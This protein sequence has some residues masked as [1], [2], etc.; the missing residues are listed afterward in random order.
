MHNL[1]LFD[2]G[3]VFAW[4][5]N[6]GGQTT[7]PAGLSGVVAIAA[8]YGH[9]LALKSDGKVVAWGSNASGQ[10]NVPAGLSGVIA[11]AGGL[12]HSLALKSDGTVVA[13]GGIGFGALGITN[14]PTGLSQVRAIAAGTYHNLALAAPATLAAMMI[15]PPPGYPL[16]SAQPTFTWGGGIGVQSPGYALWVGNNPNTYDIY[17]AVQGMN[18]SKTLTLPTDGRTLYVTLHSWINGAW[19][20]NRYT[21]AAATAAKAVMT[22]PANGSKF[23]SANVTFTWNAGIGVSKYALW[24]GSTAG[25]YDLYAQW[26]TG[27]SR[28]VTLPTDGRAIFVRL[29]S[30]INGAL[31]FN[32]YTYTAA[33]P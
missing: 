12:Q 24:V 16:I 14:V 7:V 21:Y 27:L 22:S 6:Q 25:S 5:N 26:E 29:F 18:L 1:A 23:N 9:S 4:G 31:Q 32:D 3:T 33:G 30:E 10:T 17:A 15:S 8:G 11:I 28:T 13:W 20:G 19:Q 2:N